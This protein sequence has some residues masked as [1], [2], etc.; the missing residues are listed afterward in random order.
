MF[1][2]E[3][4]PILRRVG[5]DHYGESADGYIPTGGSVLLSADSELES[6]DSSADSNADAAKVRVWVWGFKCRCQMS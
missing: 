4:R 6:V 1:D 5:D 3:S 2:K